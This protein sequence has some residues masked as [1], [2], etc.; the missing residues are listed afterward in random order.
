MSEPQNPHRKLLCSQTKKLLTKQMLYEIFDEVIREE[1]FYQDTETFEDP[2]LSVDKI[3]QDIIK[4][5][6]RKTSSKLQ[7]R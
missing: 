4:Y 3:A 2:I 6:K 7:D 5:V 1:L